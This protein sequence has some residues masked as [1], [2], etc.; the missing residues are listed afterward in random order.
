[1]KLFRICIHFQDRIQTFGN[2]PMDVEV[3]EICLL[4]LGTDLLHFIK[5]NTSQNFWIQKWSSMEHLTIDCCLSEENS[6]GNLV[7]RHINFHSNLS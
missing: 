7:E 1:M 2:G 6:H 3:Q 5:V 4:D